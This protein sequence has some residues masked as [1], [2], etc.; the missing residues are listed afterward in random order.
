MFVFIP[1]WEA[2]IYVKDIQAFLLAMDATG[3]GTLHAQLPYF[4]DIA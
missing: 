1:E 4:A 3:N 2:G